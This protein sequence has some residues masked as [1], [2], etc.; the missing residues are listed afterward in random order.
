MSNHDLQFL[1]S[2]SNLRQAVERSQ[3]W[4][5]NAEQ[6]NGIAACL[7]QGR[8]FYAAG[9]S[10]PLEIRPL[11]I[12]YGT[13][14]FGKAVSLS[15]NRSVA[16][17]SLPQR[18]GIKDTSAANALLKDLSISVDSGGV[19]QHFNDCV[20]SVNRLIYIGTDTSRET[21]RL[22][23]TPST[24]LA[25]LNLY[26]KDIFSRIPDLQS[27]YE[28][29]FM[30]RAKSDTVL[31]SSPL[32]TSGA[33]HIRADDPQICDDIDTLRSVVARWRTLAP[34]LSQWTVT[35]VGFA[36]GN[37]VIQFESF[38]HEGD[39]LADGVLIQNGR[40]FRS[41]FQ[42]SDQKRFLTITDYLDP[43]LGGYDESANT[44]VIQPIEGKF[45]S[46]YALQYLALHLLSS[47]VRYRPAIW[48]HSLSRSVSAAR[49]ADDQMLALV[50]RFLTTSQSMMLKL[51]SRIIRPD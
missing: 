13:V 31:F 34:F 20:A 9:E 23:C 21:F 11:Q 17:N 51:V 33:W 1:E 48:M 26:L 7:R 46:V 3:G 10:A 22:P 50:E 6:A 15:M 25:G 35:N 24:G 36:W 39:D 18:H 12:Y 40:D 19:F 32:L 41:A 27:L 16:L 43:S 38:Q 30:E 42:Y 45:L 4:R 44:G 5:P 2:A 28:A 37:T 29:T 8:L 49:Q 47:L 14:A